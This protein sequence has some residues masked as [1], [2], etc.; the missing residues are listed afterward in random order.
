VAFYALPYLSEKSV[1]FICISLRLNSG[2]VFD[3][4]QILMTVICHH[5]AAVEERDLQICAVS[6]HVDR[7]TEG[8]QLH[9][10]CF[11]VNF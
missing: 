4:P 3:Y 9:V 10:S 1:P 7:A 5:H 11:R 2:N 8:R 6:R